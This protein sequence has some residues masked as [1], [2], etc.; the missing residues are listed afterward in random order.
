MCQCKKNDNYKVCCGISYTEGGGSAIRRCNVASQAA[1]YRRA[2]PAQGEGN[3][4]SANYHLCQPQCWALWTQRSKFFNFICVLSLLLKSF[5]PTPS[6]L[7]PVVQSQENKWKSWDPQL[8]PQTKLRNYLRPLYTLER[9]LLQW[10]SGSKG[11]KDRT[12]CSNLKN[13]CLLLSHY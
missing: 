5:T 12:F 2:F 6:C 1:C 4:G 3:G 10:P 11:R 8:K 13:T 9:L 7:S